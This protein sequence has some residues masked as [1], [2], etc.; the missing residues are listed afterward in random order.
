L[1]RNEGGLPAQEWYKRSFEQATRAAEAF[2]K[3]SNQIREFLLEHPRANRDHAYLVSHERQ[4]RFLSYV[5]A[6]GANLYEGQRLLD[7]YS[8]K[9]VEPG[10]L[11]ELDAD[12]ARFKS[13]V[14]DEIKNTRALTNFVR[15][16]GDIGMVLLPEETTW[17]Y[18]TNLPE[19]LRRKAEIMKA[20]LPEAE[21]V[22]KRWFGSEY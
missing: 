19:L 6:T 22:F 12:L 10:L 1:F 21:S 3:A 11:R 20:H 17:G 4:L 15:E 9:E 14:E 5:Y 8:A 13:V 2:Q 7:K 18:S 16:G